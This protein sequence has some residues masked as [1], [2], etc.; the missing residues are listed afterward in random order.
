MVFC[1]H[2]LRVRLC[3]YC[4]VAPVKIS[5]RTFIATGVVGAVALA[6]ASWLR[7][8][9]VPR[10]STPRRA[11]DADAEAIMRA[12]LPVM[13][14][15]A[16]PATAPAHDAAVAQTLAGVDLEIA[17]L[18]PSAQAE[19]AQLFA[20]LALPPIR[21]GLARVAAPWPEAAPADVRRF[22]DRWRESSWTLLRSAYDALQ[23]LIYA[24]WYGNP[25]SW[26]AI[27]YTGPPALGPG[28]VAGAP[29]RPREL[30]PRAD[31]RR[32]A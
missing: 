6:T 25:Q 3:S 18:P 22:L 26:P 32:V 1:L 16:L 24:A 19:L 28:G 15:D 13:L 4:P 8:P 11:L 9:Q 12:I 31:A 23:Q 30:P 27:G 14:A 5:R 17:G 7:R 20:L 29:D 21:L 10:S 2:A